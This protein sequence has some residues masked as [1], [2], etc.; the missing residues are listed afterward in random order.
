MK[1]VTR[2]R[3]VFYVMAGCWAYFVWDAVA[4]CESLRFEE[5]GLLGA[6]LFLASLGVVAHTW[7]PQ[8]LAPLRP[9]R[10]DAEAK[11]ELVRMERAREPGTPSILLWPALRWFVLL[12]IFAICQ[13]FLGDYMV[14]AIA[15]VGW[16]TCG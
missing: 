16:I 15:R 2:I 6:V 12:L 8:I 3:L 11:A 5:L 14:E 4:R 1:I 7:N 13:F 9:G 10:T